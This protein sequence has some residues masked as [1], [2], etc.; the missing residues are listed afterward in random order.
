MPLQTLA[1]DVDDRRVWKKLPNSNTVHLTNLA[2]IQATGGYTSSIERE[3]RNFRDRSMQSMKYCQGNRDMAHG[4]TF[5][6]E[7]TALAHK[8]SKYPQVT[9]FN[10]D[11]EKES[12][13]VAHASIDLEDSCDKR[14]ARP[15]CWRKG[16]SLIVKIGREDGGRSRPRT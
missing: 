14:R 2:E 7:L 3:I 9:Q 13:T 16:V 12:W 1:Y 8:L 4:N 10:Q 11:E 6:K 15:R 5:A